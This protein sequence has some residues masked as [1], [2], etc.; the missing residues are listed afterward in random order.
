MM[1]S[2]Y[3]EQKHTRNTV[4]I[5]KLNAEIEK[6]VAKEDR[7]RKE[8]A[9]IITEIEGKAMSKLQNLINNMR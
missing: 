2:S 1:V 9:L 5:K 4:D 7:L 3:V 8:I 6:I